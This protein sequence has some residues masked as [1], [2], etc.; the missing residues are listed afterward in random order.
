MYGI[1]KKLV[2][3]LFFCIFL[4]IPDIFV[5]HWDSKLLPDI[6]G[7]EKQD[8]LSVVATGEGIEK[9]LGIPKLENA[10]GEN[11]ANV[12]FHLLQKWGIDGL[13]EIISFDTTATNTGINN[14]AA[15]LLEKKLGRNLLFLPCRH[16]ISEL[17]IKSVFELNFGKSSGPEVML[18][19]RFSKY[20]K[21]IKTS[22][23]QSGLL[24]EEIVQILT[25][26]HL[27][28]LKNFCINALKNRYVRADY[29]E[30]LQ[31][32][33]HFIGEEVPD[34]IQ[35]RLPGATSHA[36]FMAKC[37]Y[38]LKIFL[39]RSQF[40]LTTEEL[41]SLRSICIFL[42]VLYVP[43]WFRCTNTI[44]AP[45]QDLEFIQSVL[46]YFDTEVSMS[47]LEKIRKHLWYLSEET[48]GLSFFDEGIPLE[49][50]RKMVHKLK[51]END[52][53]EIDDQI[54]KRNIVSMGE[55]RCFNTKD[56]SNFVTQSTKRFFCRLNI[57]VSFF[58]S[59]PSEWH[60]RND[61]CAGKQICQ[62]L[63]VVN[64]P[65]ERAI[66]LITDYN[67]SLTYDEDDKQFL[68]QV[69]EHYRQEYPSHTKYALTTQ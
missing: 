56:M 45:K 61:Y 7:T 68:L 1:L 19:N 59:D 44:E 28:C 54:S 65:A 53:D 16:H 26:S 37:I 13:V 20:W 12:T 30:L 48:V 2:L 50:K 55:I 5:L 29:K 60:L 23:F 63:N 17:L 31:L 15:Y 66:K 22:D 36:R 32:T 57:D 34:F 33:L 6:K 38:S 43:Y 35:F 67:R 39:F 25:S 47:L 10:S 21:S 40:K 4:Q 11:T 46:S 42:T 18:F 51:I 62:H 24:D 9:L 64:D 52:S 3:R 14:G 58:Q 41:K 8:R 49:V 27:K 69:V